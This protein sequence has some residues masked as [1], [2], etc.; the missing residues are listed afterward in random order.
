M[1]INIDKGSQWET[2]DSNIVDNIKYVGSLS[3]GI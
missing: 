2:A 1:S 3:P